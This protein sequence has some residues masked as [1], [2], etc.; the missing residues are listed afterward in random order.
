MRI[1]FKT[2]VLVTSLFVIVLMAEKVAT[3]VFEVAE[4]ALTY[5]AIYKQTH[6]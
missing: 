3:T 5:Y 2:I 1:A 6:V 4:L